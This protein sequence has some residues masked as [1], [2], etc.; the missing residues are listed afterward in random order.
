MPK[1]CLMIFTCV[2]GKEYT[3]RNSLWYHQKKC[4]HVSED[5]EK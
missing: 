2:C 4:P 1:K 5:I 3:A